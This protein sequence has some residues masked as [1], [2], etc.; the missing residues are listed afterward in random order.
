MPPWTE[1]EQSL[2]VIGTPLVDTH[3]RFIR[4]ATYG[5]TLQIHVRIAEWRGKSFVQAYRVLRGEELLMECEEV[6]IFAGATRAGSTYC[7]LRLRSHDD[8]QS[9][10][11]GPD[12][13]PALLE[14]VRSTLEQ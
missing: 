6:R 2:G 4:T 9:V 14:L 10:V 8:P 1:T 12:V 13:V 7:A 11:E 5:D 3:A